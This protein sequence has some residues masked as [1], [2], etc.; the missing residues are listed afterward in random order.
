M[1][2]YVEANP[3]R[4]VNGKAVKCPSSYLWKLEDVSAS[5]AGRTEDTVMHK[6]RVG[7]L[8]GLELSWQ[9]ITTE[10]VSELLQ[11]FNPE[12]ITVC[13]LDA[14]Q[15]KYVTSE[16]YVGNRSAPM[17]N[18]VRG[19]WSNLSFNIIERSGV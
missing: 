7:Q 8:V 17:Y 3:I 11:A 19:L 13:Y 4:S 18:A 2:Q 6:K 14:M 1:A 10:D 16:F 9:N 12:Y 5:D 15:G